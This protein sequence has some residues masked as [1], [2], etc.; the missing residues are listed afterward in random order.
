MDE[1][2]LKE[3]GFSCL[4]CKKVSKTNMFSAKNLRE[5]INSRQPS[6]SSA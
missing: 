3:S 1:R 2:G 4:N 6:S 5:L